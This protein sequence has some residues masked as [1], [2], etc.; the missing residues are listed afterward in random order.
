MTT[1]KARQL[2]DIASELQHALDCAHISEA[3]RADIVRALLDGAKTM[4]LDA[5]QAV[6]VATLANDY[7]R[8]RM[9]MDEAEYQYQRGRALNAEL[10]RLNSDAARVAAAA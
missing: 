5:R 6:V 10:K 7:D 8:A 1:L 2:N 4:M 9:W 3:S